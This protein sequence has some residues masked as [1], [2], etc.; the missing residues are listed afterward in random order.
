MTREGVAE[1][2]EARDAARNLEPLAKGG[3]E[4]GGENGGNE[5][6]DG[7]G[8]DNGDGNG[9][10]GGNGYENHNVNFRGFKRV[11]RE[12]TY[13]DFLMCQP[14]NFKGTKGVVRLIRWF[15]KIETMFYISNCPQKNQMK[16]ATCTLLDSDLTWWN[17]HKRTIGIEAAYAMTWIE[18]MKLMTERGCQVYLAQV[19]SKKTEDMLEEKRLEDV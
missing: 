4:H 19:T 1:A 9:N 7:N 8:N 3:D 6:G 18:L 16:Y 17:T 2:L 14:L 15:E 5:N 10:E 12:C 13:Q 11:A